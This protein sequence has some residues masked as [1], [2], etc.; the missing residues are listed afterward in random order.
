MTA[1]VK[2]QLDQ[3]YRQARF[4][5]FDKGGGHEIRVGEP[6]ATLDAV[7]AERKIDSW[8]FVTACNP[9]SRQLS[10]GENLRRQWR[11]EQLLRADGFEILAGEGIDESGHWPPE[12]SCLILGI[13]RQQATAIALQDGQNAFVFGEPGQRAELIW[14]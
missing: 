9:K 7:L 13:S 4:R 11:M 2:E 14:C 5:V 6:C 1:Q 3:A 12:A 8:A 10:D